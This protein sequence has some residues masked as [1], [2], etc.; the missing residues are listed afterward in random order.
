[1]VKTEQGVEGDVAVLVSPVVDIDENICMGFSLFLILSNSST[2][3]RF[4]INL[5][6]PQT[7]KIASEIVH[8]ITSW[9]HDNWRYLSIPLP[10]GR[11]LIRF[12]YTMGIPYRGVVA[13]D[14]VH[15]QKCRTGLALS[16]ATDDAGMV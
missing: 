5:A 3:D 7:P 8:E 12:G 2:E 6:A 13:I 10:Q 1:M 4:Q 14:N 15:L 11:H 16:Y 9:D